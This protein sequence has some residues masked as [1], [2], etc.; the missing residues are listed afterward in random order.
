LRKAHDAKKKSHRPTDGSRTQQKGGTSSAAQLLPNC[1]PTA[2]GS[3]TTVRSYGKGVKGQGKV[4]RT[5]SSHRKQA[6]RPQQ[7][8]SLKKGGQ[9]TEPSRGIG[10][11]GRVN[12]GRPFRKPEV[13]CQ[14]GRARSMHGWGE[15]QGTEVL[16]RG[17][18]TGR[19]SNKRGATS[20]PVRGVRGR[21]TGLFIHK[22]G[23]VGL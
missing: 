20:N 21:R 8:K 6:S 16:V 10:V 14:L 11:A 22:G 18:A 12:G 3:Q 19:G 17:I 2:E 1:S 23:I 9:R 7:K 13:H 15:R 5:T 4:E